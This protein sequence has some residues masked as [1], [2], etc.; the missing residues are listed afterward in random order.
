MKR[1]LDQ[2]D[3]AILEQ[4]Y[5][6]V[7][8]SNRKIAAALSITEGTVRTRI[9]RMKDEGSVRFTAA[10][11]SQVYAQPVIGYIGVNISGAD[12]RA[13]CSQLAELSELNFISL[14]LGRYD[15]LCTFLLRDSTQLRDLLQEKIPAI[16]GITSTESVQALQV[17]K[18]DRRWSVL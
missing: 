14:M 11:D 13:V 16:P 4:L 1:R 3:K 2:I 15:V 8:I 5:V 12:K 18:F 9:K 17:Y 10:L 6:D 7:R